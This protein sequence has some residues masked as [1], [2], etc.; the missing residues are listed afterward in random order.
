VAFALAEP[1]GFRCDACG[2]TGRHP[3]EVASQLRG[4]QALLSRTDAASRQL[5]AMQRFSLRASGALIGVYLFLFVLAL[6]P[7]GC[8]AGCAVVQSVGGTPAGTLMMGVWPA[9]LLVGGVLGLLSMVRTRRRL[10][11]ATAA[12]PPAA[13]GA[14]ARC[15]VCGGPLEPRATDV[16]VRCGYCAADCVVTKGVLDEL[17]TRLRL[18]TDRWGDMV[19]RS[20]TA[21]GSGLAGLVL[22]P[23]ALLLL[24][25]AC[26]LC[27]ASVFVFY[28]DQREDPPDRTV[29]YVVERVP[30]V[31]LSCVGEVERQAGGQR[32][33]FGFYPR[34]HDGAQSYAR[35]L[36]PPLPETIAVEELVGHTVF[37]QVPSRGFGEERWTVTGAFA[38]PLHDGNLLRLR[39]ESDGNVQRVELGR[40]MVC[41]PA[42]EPTP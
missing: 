23:L 1:D 26:Y 36:E 35:A 25:V 32:A 24:P 38:P 11:E 5:G 15:R 17:R 20:A 10:R 30:R 28:L 22:L 16:I 31:E 27:I 14:P 8:S 42:G 3:P 9:I 18:T 21:I 41:F 34:E 7:A 13:P 40:T 12:I 37:A 19:L 4:A 39:S 2:A 29:R 6:V 33:F